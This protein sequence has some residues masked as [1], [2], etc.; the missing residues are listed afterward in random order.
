[1]VVIFKPL[2]QHFHHILCGVTVICLNV[3]SLDCI[4][5]CLRHPIVL[6]AIGHRKAGFQ[7]YSALA[8][9]K[10]VDPFVGIY[11]AAPESQLLSY[12]A[13]GNS[14]EMSHFKVNVNLMR[15]DYLETDELENAEVIRSYP[16]IKWELSENFFPF[17]KEGGLMESEQATFRYVSRY[18]KCPITYRPRY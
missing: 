8:T 14:Q 10:T 6:G 9:S 11:Q 18:P 3:S 1:L 5:K 7:V 13:F 2:V 12:R 15:Y 17:L 16:L 4:H